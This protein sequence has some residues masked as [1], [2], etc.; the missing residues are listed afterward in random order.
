MQVPAR[1]AIGN[2]VHAH[3]FRLVPVWLTTDLQVSQDMYVVII[4][5]VIIMNVSKVQ[6]L[7]PAAAKLEALFC[8]SIF[9]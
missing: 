8:L 9:V 3:T 4:V 5:I 1:Y 7:E 6:I 2:I